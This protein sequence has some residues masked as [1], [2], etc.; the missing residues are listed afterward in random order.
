MNGVICVPLYTLQDANRH[1]N[2]S[3]KLQMHLIS[4]YHSKLLHGDPCESPK[5]QSSSV[6]MTVRWTLKLDNS[7]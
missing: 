6:N 4:A 2:D 7:L 3:L 1:Y 5:V